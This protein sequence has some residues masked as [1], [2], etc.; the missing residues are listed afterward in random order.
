LDALSFNAQK[1]MLQTDVDGGSTFVFRL[2]PAG[3]VGISVRTYLDALVGLIH[4][5]LAE[6]FLVYV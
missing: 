3:R 6:D 2:V 5:I 4:C 1:I